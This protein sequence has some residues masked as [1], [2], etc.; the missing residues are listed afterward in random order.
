MASATSPSAVQTASSSELLRIPVISLAGWFS[1]DAPSQA[2]VVSSV[3]DAC[4][5][6]GF[7]QVSDHR[8]PASIVARAWSASRA[9]FDSPLSNK[10]SAPQ[11]ADYPY[12]YVAMEKEIAGG[13]LAVADEYGVADRKESFAI[14]LG[15]STGASGVPPPRWPPA[16]PELPEALSDYF[17]AME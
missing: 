17:Y 10:A 14:A 4:S 16:P 3:A 6:C 2:A 11:T 1:G 7:F 8:V 15:S 13:S 5:R 12:G 9:F